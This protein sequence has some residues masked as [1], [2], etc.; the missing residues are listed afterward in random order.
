MTS[1][2]IGGA[3]TVVLDRGLDVE[4]AGSSLHTFT[5]LT[6]NHPPMSRMFFVTFY[7]EHSP[8]VMSMTIDIYLRAYLL[9][10]W[11]FFHQT[12]PRDQGPVC[13]TTAVPRVSWSI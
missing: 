13:L 6:C 7:L 5:C 4:A 1:Q 12:D 11:F 2:G 8:P 9:N 3:L 10:A